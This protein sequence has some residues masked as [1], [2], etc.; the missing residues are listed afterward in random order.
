MRSGAAK[1]SILVL[2]TALLVALLS[3]CGVRAQDAAEAAPTGAPPAAELGR[4]DQSSGPQL[5]VFFVRSADLA[6]V[7][8]RVS[9]SSP[10]AALAQVVDG[11][12]RSEAADG[13]R[14]AL[15]PEVVGVEAVGPDGTATVAVSRGFAGITG[16][17]QLLAV[18]QIVWTLTALPT[19]EDVQFTVEG[20]PVEV[21]TDAGLSSGPVDRGDF[22]SV[23]PAEPTAGVPST[24]AT[25]S[26]PPP[27]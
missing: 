17:N 19:V 25:G 4:P 23:A 1:Q 27:R 8:R 18:A 2:F 10:A 11:P 12:T 26:S 5:T 16:G 9:A 24:S 15:A 20:I 22:R 7:D 21:P 6:P 13:I 3:S 14:T